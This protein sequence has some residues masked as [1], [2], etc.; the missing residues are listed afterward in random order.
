ME[1]GKGVDPHG[2][3]RIVDYGRDIK[4]SHVARPFAL[5]GLWAAPRQDEGGKT[6]VRGPACY[7]GGEGAPAKPVIVVKQRRLKC[8]DAPESGFS[9]RGGC[10]IFPG[11][12]GLWSNVGP[13]AIVLGKL[14]ARRFSGP[15]GEG[16][17]VS[18]GENADGSVAYCE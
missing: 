13:Q 16:K 14:S 5:G 17:G 9:T 2:W 3:G 11:I 12:G 10:Q 15:Q 7:G 4:R 8:R 6:E 1:A 18:Y